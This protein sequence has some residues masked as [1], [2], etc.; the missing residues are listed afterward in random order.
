LVASQ[1]DAEQ[2]GYICYMKFFV[3]ISDSK[4]D[5]LLSQVPHEVKKKVATEFGINLKILTAKRTATTEL[6][7]SK[8]KRLEAVVTYIQKF[9]NVGTVDE[10]DEYFCDTMRMRWGPYGWWRVDGESSGPRPVY[11][12]GSTNK[13]VFG[14]GGSARH[15]IGEIGGA[16]NRD[17]EPIHSHSATPFLLDYF[18]R[19]QLTSGELSRADYDRFLKGHGD[20][21]IAGEQNRPG[22]GLDAIEVATEAMRGPQQRLEFLAKRLLFRA[23]VGTARRVLLG[24]PLYVALAE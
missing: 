17:G 18:L 16:N 14:M 8:I 6:D 1:I 22:L 23:E 13:T 21:R 19:E 20:V 3:Y 9:G 2:I 5:M 15:I 10:P 24:S 7:D 11:F 12:G 4:V